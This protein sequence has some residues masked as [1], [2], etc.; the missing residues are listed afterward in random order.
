MITPVWIIGFTGHRPKE[1]PGRTSA[2]M[3]H[4]AVKIREELRALKAKAESQGGRAELLCGVAAGADLIAA[5]EAAVLEMPV[6]VILPMPE[7]HFEED[8]E[9]V[10]FQDDLKQARDFIKLAKEGI[11][12]ATFRIAHGSHLRDDC[13]YDVGSQIVYA[14]DVIIALWD[15][16][17]APPVQIT[18]STGKIVSSGRGG[19]ADVI[20]MANADRMPYLKGKKIKDGYRWLPTPVRRINTVTG[21]VD[22]DSSSFASA[23][24]AGLAEMKAIQHAADAEHGIKEPLAT[25]K[26]LMGFVD[27]GA[28]DWAAKLRGALLCGSIL[29]FT[30]S[31]IAAVS[32]GSQSVLKGWQPPALAG[33]ELALVLAAIGLMLWSHYKHAQARWLELRVATE[34]VRGLVS[35]GRLF[36]PLFPIATD[37]LPGWR[38]FCVSAGLTIWRDASTAA[39]PGTA[40]EKVFAE[41]KTAY[42]KD[43][44]EDQIRHFETYDPHHRHWWH[45][46]AHFAGSAT[47]FLAVVFIVIALVHKIDVYRHPEHEHPENLPLSLIYYFLPIALPLLAGAVTSLQSVTDVKRRAHVYPEMV[48]RLKSACDF[49]AAIR[50][51][52]SLRRFVRRT[53]EILLDELV[54]WYAAA[55]GISH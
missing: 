24:D 16:K 33:L 42:L 22:G 26:A 43:R 46:S 39:A 34:L 50:T 51:P 53:E 30:A 54:G 5:R 25:A 40:P 20:D 2:E 14:S 17:E 49:L 47:S 35:S 1:S 31:I 10:A 18:D 7:S 52:T 11:G 32:A 41:E 45:R 8:F 23:T 55:K 9:G 3:E 4:L 15:G 28:K 21:E 36:D 48:E 44:I 13:Y 38:R 29:H 27:R 6:H 12:G 19:T 37:H